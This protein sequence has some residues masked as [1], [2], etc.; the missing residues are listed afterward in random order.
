NMALSSGSTEECEALDADH[1]GTI[2]ID[3]I[4]QAVNDALGECPMPP[5]VTF[6]EIQQ[7]IFTPSCAIASCHD[8]ISHTANLN[9]Q[10]DQ[11]YANLANVSPD[12][13]AAAQAGLLRVKPNS[14]DESFLLIKLTG[15]PPSEG[16]KMPLTGTPLTAEQIDLVRN[17]ILQGA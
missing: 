10:A 13:F 2:T 9:L 5:A 15:P 3:E 8:H 11:S 4:L 7:T 14:P 1:S 12:P 6:D 16:S 17:W